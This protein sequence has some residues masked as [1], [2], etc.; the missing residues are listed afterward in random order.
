MVDK[1]EKNT[2]EMAHCP[3]M[4]YKYK[5]II[6]GVSLVVKNS[7]CNAMQCKRHGFNPQSRKI[8]HAMEQLVHAPQLVSQLGSG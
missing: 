5:E 8:P 4:I 6:L 3:V 1:F 7:P 2:C